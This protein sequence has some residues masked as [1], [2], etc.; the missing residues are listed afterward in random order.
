ML[1]R[2]VEMV[3][4]LTLI[5]VAVTG[6]MLFSNAPTPAPPPAQA[7]EIPAGL[8]AAT[9]YSQSCAGCHG[10]DG[11]GGIGPPLKSARMLDRFPN[12]A[13]QRTVVDAGRGRMPAF[14]SQLGADEI[15]AIV[16]YTR[17]SLS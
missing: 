3:Q 15:D 1:R 17:T 10:G 12:V 14:G 16:E 13:D 7:A 9:L 2:I 5:G 6:T 11:S 8:D 4:I